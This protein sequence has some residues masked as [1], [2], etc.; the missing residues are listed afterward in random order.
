MTRA[1]GNSLRIPIIASMPFR[2]GI[3]RSINVTSG[4]CN[5]NFS[6]ASCPLEAS[7]INFMSDSVLT[8]AA[9]PS[10][11]RAWSSTVRIRIG[12]ESARMSSHLFAE[13]PESVGIVGFHVSNGGG[14]SQ[15]NLCACFG[16]APDIQS[17]PY[18]FRTFTDPGQPPV[19]GAPAFL[20]DSG[21]NALS[22]IPDTQ[23]KL[24]V[25]VPDL[26][27]DLTCLCVLERVS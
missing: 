25:V 5:R 16:F 7:A 13:K 24:G 21:V 1:L 12:L 17:C 27:F 4:R 26:G 23:A 6:I 18:L 10:R 11:R 9:I 20:Q 22:I 15:L 8:S 3:C 19:S 14:N 2:A